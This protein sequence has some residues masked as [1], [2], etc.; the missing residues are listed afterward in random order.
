MA[1]TAGSVEHNQVTGFN[2]RA[3]SVNIG[4]WTASSDNGRFGQYSVVCDRR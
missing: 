2:E 4:I 3:G 1:S